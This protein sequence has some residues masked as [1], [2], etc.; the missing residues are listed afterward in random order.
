MLFTFGR[1]P[2]TRIQEKLLNHT[3]D[4]CKVQAVSDGLLQQLSLPAPVFVEPDLRSLYV[5]LANLGKAFGENQALCL[6]C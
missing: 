4:F 2:N 6:I 3:L 1:N 5:L